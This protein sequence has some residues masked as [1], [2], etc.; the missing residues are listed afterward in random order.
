MN[1]NYL[2]FI[3]LIIVTALYFF[4]V[5]NL[6][7]APLDEA[8]IL[9]GAERILKG[10]IPNKDFFTVY[11]PGQIYTLSALFRLFGISVTVER[12]YD[13]IVKILLSL[14]VFLVIKRLSSDKIALCG[15][16]MSL[17]WIEYSTFPAYPVY[18]TLFFILIS[19]S[20]ILF[21]MDRPKNYYIFLSAVSIMIAIL[22][23]H[24]LGGLAAIAIM[25]VLFLRKMMNVHRSWSPMITFIL[26]VLIT[27]LPVIF[28]VYINSSIKL[29]V[30]DLILYPAL[31]LPKY[32]E[33]PYPPLSR[34]NLPFYVF[35]LVMVAGII[36]F[37]ILNRRE[38]NKTVVYGVLLV[39]LIGLFFLNQVRVRSD[40]IHLLPVAMIGIILAPILLFVLPRALSVS[41]WQ[42]RTLCVLFI[43]FFTITLSK[44]IGRKFRSFPKGYS[45]K[46]VNPEIERA[47]YQYIVPDIKQAVAFIKK[48]TSEDDYIYVGVINHDR[49]TVNHP[50]IYFLTERRSATKYHE[51]NPGLINTLRTQEVMVG[52]LKDKDVPVVVLAEQ[53]WEEPNL[54]SADS[55]TNILDNY[56]KANYKLK[57]TYGNFEIWTKNMFY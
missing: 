29:M 52:E 56:I 2:L 44:P 49:F 47:R 15:W 41:T 39:S 21:Y 10:Q 54:S 28:I 24:D 26:S 14:S 50:I 46:E 5:I 42:Y 17:I 32:S 51:F 36:T 8:V 35:P 20:F 37:L 27:A 25:L 11:P 43:V 7:L 19:V 38:I 18:P 34:W 3:I 1:K 23:R 55:G 48:I 16:V 30:D 31:V 57:K 53:P 13:I 4:P 45:V 9:V 40:L 6:P 22:F 12:M 33:L